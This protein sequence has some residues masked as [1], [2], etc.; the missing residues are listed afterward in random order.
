MLQKISIEDAHSL[1]NNEPK[2]VIFDV[3]DQNSYAS[4][5]IHNAIHLSKENF[6]TEC[7][8]ITTDTPV[9]VY[10]FRGVSSQMIGQM[11]IHH[12]ITQVY[13]MDGGFEAW[14]QKYQ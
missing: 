12:G 8:K 5:H 13:S 1:I 3:R 11:L 2:L 14:K 9:L 4:K 7:E 10:C 6:E